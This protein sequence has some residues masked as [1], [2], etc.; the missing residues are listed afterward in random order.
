MIDP[1]LSSV[2]GLMPVHPYTVKSDPVCPRNIA[3]ERIT[4][5]KQLFFGRRQRG[6]QDRC[7]ELRLR[8]SVPHFLRQKNMLEKRIQSGIMKSF[9]LCL[10]YPVAYQKQPE[11]F[12]F[13]L[14]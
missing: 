1:Q 10:H 4:D 13:L 12:N 7:K 8:L 6:L 9:I 11:I 3:G 5:Q 2:C 14:N